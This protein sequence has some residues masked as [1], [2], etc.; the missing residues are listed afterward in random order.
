MSV[1]LAGW[2]AL[3]LTLTQRTNER[4]DER[5]DERTANEQTNERIRRNAQHR[6]GR[7]R[8]FEGTAEMDGRR[9]RPKN[10]RLDDSMRASGGE[11]VT[12]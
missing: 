1:W 5:M 12:A 9:Q 4:T 8:R 10:R 7:I 3:N 2:L 11:V 6:H